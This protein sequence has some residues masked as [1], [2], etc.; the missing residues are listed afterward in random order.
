MWLESRD[1]PAS[2]S[3]QCCSNAPRWRGEGRR[4][5]RKIRV[6][7]EVEGRRDRRAHALRTL[8]EGGEGVMRRDRL[9]SYEGNAG[10]RAEFVPRH[11]ATPRLITHVFTLWPPKL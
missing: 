10:R 7:R 8:A 1:A 4:L 3:K 2:V 6:R 9:L 5:R 11:G